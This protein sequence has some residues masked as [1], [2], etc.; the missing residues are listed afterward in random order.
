MRPRT[1]RAA[2]PPLRRPAGPATALAFRQLQDTA[3]LLPYTD[4][5]VGGVYDFVE[6]RAFAFC[7]VEPIKGVYSIGVAPD[8]EAQPAARIVALLAH[9][10]GH[11][12]LLRRGHDHGEQAADDEAERL[13][14]FRIY[15]DADD[16]QTTDTTGVYP[17]PAH[18]PK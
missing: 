13:F 17:R 4:L 8:L 9:E 11:A 6:P 16:V 7:H 5:Y 12:S 10:L 18:L 2:G 14:G 1:K 15:Y 3:R